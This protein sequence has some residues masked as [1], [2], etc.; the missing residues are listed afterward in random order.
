MGGPRFARLDSVVQGFDPQAIANQQHKILLSIPNGVGKHS[1]QSIHRLWPLLFIEM[2][3]D[4]SIATGLKAMAFLD[5]LLTE[6]AIV[7]DLPVH[8]RPDGA[9]LVPD[10]LTSTGRI[11]HPQSPYTKGHAYAMMRP[12]L[13]RS[14]MDKPIEH[15]VK[16]GWI[17]VPY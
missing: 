2:H 14:S 10:R 4:F 16:Q 17:I 7:V 13:V 11:N 12:F 8:H 9:G 15:P 5:Q 3:Q 6:F 1:P